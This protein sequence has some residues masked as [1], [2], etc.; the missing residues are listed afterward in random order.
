VGLGVENDGANGGTLFEWRM[1]EET[2]KRADTIKVADP[3]DKISRLPQ[4]KPLRQ[5]D[6]LDPVPIR[7]PLDYSKLPQYNLDPQIINPQTGVDIGKISIA[8][9]TLLEQGASA[10]IKKIVRKDL[11]EHDE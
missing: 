5:L 7:Q 3:V 2:V 4:I 10:K 6:I 8:N 1:N 9:A 11:Q